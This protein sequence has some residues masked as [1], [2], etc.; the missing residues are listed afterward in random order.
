MK[1]LVHTSSSCGSVYI[2]ES[3]KAVAELGEIFSFFPHLCIQ[4]FNRA[5]T[6]EEFDQKC[7]MNK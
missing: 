4:I 5:G 7:D 3:H 6:L 1:E 2:F